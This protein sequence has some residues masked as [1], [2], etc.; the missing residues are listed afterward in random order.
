MLDSIYLKTKHSSIR[1]IS[2]D[3]FVNV[4]HCK[5]ILFSFKTIIKKRNKL[6]GD[7]DIALNNVEFVYQ[8]I[9][10]LLLI[11]FTQCIHFLITSA[12]P[13]RFHVG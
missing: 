10:K 11:L 1:Y 5:G 2:L 3:V 12:L 7:D 9:V 8:G 13:R 4:Y 6:I